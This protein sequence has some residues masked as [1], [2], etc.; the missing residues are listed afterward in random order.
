MSVVRTNHISNRIDEHLDK[1]VDLG[2]A[3][4]ER[5]ARLVLQNEPRFKEFV[6]AMG[7]WFFVDDRGELVDRHESMVQLANFIGEFDRYLKLTGNP[8]RFEGYHGQIVRD[9]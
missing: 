3:E 8:M 2:L 5:L 1:A 4:V 7:G 9:W 6:M